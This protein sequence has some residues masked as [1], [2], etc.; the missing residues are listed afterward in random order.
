MFKARNNIQ[1]QVLWQGKEG[2]QQQRV[3]PAKNSVCIS[4][5]GG[6]KIKSSLFM[7]PQN[8]N[9]IVKRRKVGNW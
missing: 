3:R 8:H 7:N 9:H 1:K 5:Y 2:K 4:V 6:I